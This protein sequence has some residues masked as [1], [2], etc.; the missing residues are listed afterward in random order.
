VPVPCPTRRRTRA[1]HGHSRTSRHA[2]GLHQRRCTRCLPSWF[3]LLPD[4]LGCVGPLQPMI[5]TNEW[6]SSAAPKMIS[7]SEALVMR[8][9]EQRALAIGT[10]RHLKPCE[11]AYR[12]ARD[13]HSSSRVPAASP[14]RLPD[15]GLGSRRQASS[16]DHRDGRVHP[17][18][19]D[20]PTIS[21]LRREGEGGARLPGRQLRSCAGDPPEEWLTSGFPYG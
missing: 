14:R 10:A 3:S 9:N 11:Y 21:R 18:R 5:E 1:I 4:L 8:R 16:S 7:P 20:R 17:K 15:G 19:S 12:R 6:R 2:T 13:I